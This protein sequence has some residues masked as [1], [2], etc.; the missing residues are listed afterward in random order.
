M[1]VKVCIFGPVHDYGSQS[2]TFR[3]LL[4]LQVVSLART[5]PRGLG[6]VSKEVRTCFYLPSARITSLPPLHPT[7]LCGFL[8][9]ELSFSSL[10]STQ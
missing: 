9:F 10:H 1:C 5:S 6:W 2:L 8:R 7:L 3:C 4:C